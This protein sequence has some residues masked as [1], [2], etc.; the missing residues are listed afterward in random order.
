MHPTYEAEA[1]GAAAEAAIKPKPKKRN[2]LKKSLP[3]FRHKL[4]HANDPYRC[5]NT[6]ENRSTRLV[7]L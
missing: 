7:Q 4:Q 1:E 3:E 5:T 6:V 2:E